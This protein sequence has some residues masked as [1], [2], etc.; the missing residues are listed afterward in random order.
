MSVHTF[1]RVNT[2]DCFWIDRK[3]SIAIQEK[4]ETYNGV[5]EKKIP[6]LTFLTTTTIMSA[7]TGE[8]TRFLRIPVEAF[9]A[10]F[11]FLCRSIFHSRSDVALL[12]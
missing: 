8:G 4:S 9:F 6:K 1:L 2:K 5:K 3:K 10:F 12:R 11:A 7:V